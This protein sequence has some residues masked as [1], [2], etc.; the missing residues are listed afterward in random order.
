MNPVM[1]SQTGSVAARLAEIADEYSLRV[2]AGE[3][4]DIEEFARRHP[5]MASIL[6][7][8]LPA[9]KFLGCSAAIT[10]T[11][12]AVEI[13]EGPV[14]SL[15]LRQLGDFRL[16]RE[17][18]RGGMGVVFEAEQLSL[19]RRVALKVL[20]LAGALD[21]HQLARFKNE[22]LA[23]AQLEHPHIVDVFGV[24]CHGGVHFYVMR[25][26]AGR[27]LAQILAAARESR[28][29]PGLPRFGTSEYFARVAALILQA[30]QALDHAHEMGVVHRDVK[31]GNLL[32]DNDGHLWV[33]DFGLARSRA[34][35]EITLTGDLLGT[36]RYMSPEQAQGPR[37]TVDGRSDVYSLG[38]TMFELLTLR[39]LREG[40][41]RAALLRAIDVADELSPL[42]FEPGVPRDLE[43]IALKCLA[44]EPESRYATA[45]DLADDLRRFLE[46]RP[47][48]A[49]RPSLRQRAAK[50]CARYRKFVAAVLFGVVAVATAATVVAWR[51][52][53]SA[54]RQ[55]RLATLAREAVNRFFTDVSENPRLLQQEPGT[56]ELRRALLARAKEYYEELA[57]ELKGN[58][59]LRAELAGAYRR[60]GLITMEMGPDPRAV[61]YLEQSRAILAELAAERQQNDYAYELASL[62]NNIGLAL[63]SGSRAEEMFVRGR[64]ILQPI[65]DGDPLNARA[66]DLMAKLWH[67]EGRL[68][69]RLAR[70]RDA[71]ERYDAAHMIWEDL[72]RREPG[73]RGYGASLAKLR[74][75]QGVVLK[76]TGDTQ[77]ALRLFL[78]ADCTDGLL[79]AGNAYKE[80]GEKAESLDCFQ[81]AVDRLEREAEANPGLSGVR[82]GLAVAYEARGHV[83]RELSQWDDCRA[84]Y[85]RAQGILLALVANYPASDGYRSK[86]ASLYINLGGFLQEQGEL[87]SAVNMLNSACV[88]MRELVR[89]RPQELSH[90]NSLASA[91][92]NLGESQAKL[93]QEVEATESFREAR[94]IMRALHDEHADVSRYAIVLGAN[95]CNLANNLLGVDGF[96]DEA[97]QAYSEGIAA[98]QGVIDKEGRNDTAARFLVN[99]LNGRGVLFSMARNYADAAADWRRALAVAPNDLNVL[100]NFARLLVVCP[101]HQVRDFVQ[102][103]AL[104]KRAVELADRSPQAWRVLGAAQFR[105]EDWEQAVASLR[106]VEQ[107]GAAAAFD[108]FFLAMSHRRLDQIEEARLAFEK[109]I[110]SIRP[111]QAQDPEIVGLRDEAD[112]LIN[113]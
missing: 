91:L 87:P 13:T 58:R 111:D 69:Q 70:S 112:A 5:E 98:L 52:L 38:A 97:L 33:A 28:E 51:E 14:D 11:E 76:E 104:A 27:S 78:S 55:D 64:M 92:T 9:I 102:A 67:N 107:S 2:T 30:A 17:I 37:A 96:A 60:L 40:E 113:R 101:D 53:E 65:L 108:Y 56:Q 75:S 34:R 1:A 63:E 79:N 43:T 71:L 68:H 22:A 61:E 24:G 50:W 83:E 12:G 20:P 85:E 73:D 77:S 41:D 57:A 62:D 44:R 72:A 10:S 105:V 25:Y 88:T 100:N 99:S 54:R 46:N 8:V 106:K 3:S 18:G 93:G 16:V 32:L 36:L 29:P 74:V 81:R 31:P 49:A 48:L 45:A 59:A 26:V 35:P 42:R 109:A 82:Y 21:P 66:A 47:I 4:P 103:L 89:K 7:Q 19:A 15:A 94:S 39:P 90:R 80:L 6:R 84:S 95:D 86:L 23:A 110:A